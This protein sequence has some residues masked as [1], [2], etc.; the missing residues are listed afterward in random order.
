MALIEQANSSYLGEIGPG[1]ENLIK[2]EFHADSPNVKWLTDITEF[3]IPAGKVYLPPII[4]CYDGM[5]ISWSV[6]TSPNAELVNSMLDNAIMQLGEKEFPIIHSDRGAH[7]RLPG[8]IERINNA[9]LAR[10]MSKKGCSP[11]NS[12]CEGFFGR[13]KNEMFYC[14]SWI[15]ISIDTFIHELNH[16]INWYNEKRIKISLGGLSPLQYRHKQ[17]EQLL[18]A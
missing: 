5:V 16:Y 7:Y 13:L 1:I 8:W 9:Q 3:Q 2:R 14:K 4:D 11:D 10:S 17:Q 12:A 6:G 15:D 18:Y